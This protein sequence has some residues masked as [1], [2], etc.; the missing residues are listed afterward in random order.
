VYV[1]E[2]SPDGAV[3]LG[4]EPIPAGTLLSVEFEL[5]AVG[6][7]PISAQVVEVRRSSGGL[8]H[9]EHWIRFRAM[10]EAARDA[11]CI[12]VGENVAERSEV[13]TPAIGERRDQPRVWVGC[14]AVALMSWSDGD[15]TTRVGSLSHGGAFL[16]I[17]E[18]SACAAVQPG[19]VVDVDM[20][21]RSVPER[22]GVTARVV[23]YNGP[24]EPFG[25]GLRF[26]E[27]TRMDRA[28]LDGVIRYIHGSVD[29]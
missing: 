19:A 17:Q 14:D 20:A 15:I 3:L 1:S 18:G 11:L 28:R 16:A 21:L 6:V 27:M 2:L 12:A 5:S 29:E 9:L 25:V 10:S 24:S 23:R 8:A 4:L 13:V 7:P 26:V 22:F